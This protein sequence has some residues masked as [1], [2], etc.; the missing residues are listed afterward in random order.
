VDDTYRILTAIV[1]HEL[2]TEIPPMGSE[3][4]LDDL[5]GWD[6]VA[7]AGV[8]LAIEERFQVAAVRR[9]LVPT[10]GAELLLLCNPV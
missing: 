7:L 9:D 4:I 1:Q 6:S 8:L 10:T 5:P 2:Q 3:T